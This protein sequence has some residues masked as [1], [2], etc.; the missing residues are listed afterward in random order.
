MECLCLFLWNFKKMTKENIFSVQNSAGCSFHAL[1][2]DVSSTGERCHSGFLL[3][4]WS[5]G[6][7][8]AAGTTSEGG[9]AS[10]APPAAPSCFS[11]RKCR[12]KQEPRCGHTARKPKCHLPH[13]K[14]VNS[15]GP[16]LSHSNSL[17]TLSAKGSSLYPGHHTK[18]V[19][20]K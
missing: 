11:A 14:A 6:R 4:R 7:A 1:T 9:A 3:W 16:Q 18:P 13:C 2:E 5:P 20:Q 10:T 8:P 17:T 19:L 15:P 12:R